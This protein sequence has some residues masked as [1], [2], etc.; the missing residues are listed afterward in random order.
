M[1]GISD[2]TSGRG[3]YGYTG[4]STG[5]TYGVYGETASSSGTAVYGHASAASGPA[6]GVVGRV[7]SPDGNGVSGLSD[8]TTGFGIGVYGK[9]NSPNGW[10]IYSNGNAHI[11]G[12]LTWKPI[13]STLSVPPAAF[14]PR[15]NAGSYNNYGYQLSPGGSPAATFFYAPVNLP[16]GATVTKFTFH[17]S[18]SSGADGSASLIQN[19]AASSPVEMARADTSG[20]AG[21]SSSTDAVITNAA[22]DNTQN[23]YYIGLY[24]PD[25]NVIAYAIYIEYTIDRPY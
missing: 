14:V 12:Q 6:L 22:I 10:G 9:S 17:W 2:S 15:N 4:T 3:V 11:E 5:T 19:P 16:H 1:Y 23:S 18:D 7:E 21:A 20:N 24:L 13:T 8:A 25:S